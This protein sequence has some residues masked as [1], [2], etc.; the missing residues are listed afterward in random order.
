MTTVLAAET[1][2]AGCAHT[3]SGAELTPQELHD[4]SACLLTCLP[5]PGSPGPVPRQHGGASVDASL[6]AGEGLGELIQ[7]G[8]A[9][10]K[11]TVTPSPQ[12]ASRFLVL[13]VSPWYSSGWYHSDTCQA[14][15]P[16]PEAGQQLNLHSGSEV[17]HPP[18]QPEDAPTPSACIFEAQP[19]PEEGSW[20]RR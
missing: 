14:R 16:C 3:W 15:N 7:R 19:Q 2:R 11:T 18:S 17:R 12:Q 1:G 4:P 10:P 6:G 8:R 9:S 5:S 13:P 20:A